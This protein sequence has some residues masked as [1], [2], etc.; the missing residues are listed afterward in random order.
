MGTEIYL[1][2]TIII[3]IMKIIIIEAIVKVGARLRGR[4]MFRRVAF[5]PLPKKVNRPSFLFFSSL[6]ISQLRRVSII[7]GMLLQIRFA[8]T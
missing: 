6:A 7:A 2:I 1:I 3:I 8:T 5:F 4:F